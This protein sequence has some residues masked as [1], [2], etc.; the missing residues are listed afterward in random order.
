MVRI[1]K[2]T[3]LIMFLAL[4]VTM[5]L[6]INCSSK[7]VNESKEA[8]AATEEKSDAQPAGDDVVAMADAGS[9][10][11]AEPKEK[12]PVESVLKLRGLPPTLDLVDE[13]GNTITN[14]YF[15]GKAYIVSFWAEQCEVCLTQMKA[16]SNEI[17]DKGYDMQL[18]A[19]SPG[20]DGPSKKKEAQILRDKGIKSIAAFDKEYKTTAGYQLNGVPYFA[21]VDKKNRLQAAGQML[22]HAKMKTLTLLEMMALINR[23]GDVPLCEFSPDGPTENYA[24]LVGKEAAVL[25][26]E[27]FLDN[28]QE[29]TIYY[30][31]FSKILV[32]FWSPTCPH[33][34]AELPRLEAFNREK[35]EELN[36][37][38]IGFAAQPEDRDPE[39][40]K[41]TK[42]LIEKL[43]VTFPNIPDY[44]T[45][46][47]DLYKVKG[48]PSMFII[49]LD[50]R[51]EHAISGEMLFTSEG[52]QCM[53]NSIDSKGK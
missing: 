3:S 28:K 38:I 27:T 50:G 29:S 8:P 32:V 19:I 30:K 33:C 43:G 37:K 26:G 24:E 21:I 36:I 11:K 39:F 42:G 16:I 40:F 31:G 49:G 4:A 2:I 48:V 13:M 53:L 7:N 47:Q 51:I 17:A 1:H 12:S 15:K 25:S 22:T 20:Q 18:L 46:F 10:K 45:K 23:G 44:G 52:I 6:P 14:D 9:A 5:M 34:R 41:G 35:A